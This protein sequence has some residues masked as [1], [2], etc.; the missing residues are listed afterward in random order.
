MS[1]SLM[2]N[3]PAPSARLL[4][5]IAVLAA[6][7]APLLATTDKAEARRNSS[8]SARPAEAKPAP[9]KGPL[10]LVVSLRR[11]R[12][13][14]YGPD[15]KITESPVSTGRSGHETPTGVFSVIGKEVMHYSNLYGDAPMPFMNRITWSGVALH[16]GALPGYPASHGC[17]RLPY[18]FARSLYGM[19]KVGTRVIVAHDDATPSSIVH[20]NLF[21]PLP[22]EGTSSLVTAATVAT[23]MATAV[24]SSGVISALIGITPA[25]AAEPRGLERPVRTREM[26]VAERAEELNNIIAR[27]KAAED[28]KA[29]REPKA[30]AATQDAIEARL[31]QRNLQVES[32]RLANEIKRL[33][34]AIENAKR[35]FEKL[36]RVSERV[37]GERAMMRAVEK[38]EALEKTLMESSAALEKTRA[39]LGEVEAKFKSAEESVERAESA[40]AT[41]FDELKTV[42]DEL[43]TGQAEKAAAEKAAANR[44]KPITVLISR[45]SGKLHV[46]Q[47]YDDVF[48]SPVTIAEP[49]RPFGTHV[50]TAV[51]YTEGE[52]NLR[53][54]VVTA[55][56]D[57]PRKSRE[58]R[59][60]NRRKEQERSEAPA[61]APSDPTQALARVTIPA[62]ARERIAELIKPGSTLMLS[63]HGISHE[64]GKY[65][66]YILLTR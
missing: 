33:E 25:A 18:G 5:L 49:E 1:R 2:R 39:Q 52:K 19:T 43:R 61:L 11:Q 15:G 17:I 22:S 55:A 4:H 41:A 60:R 9:P 44:A 42:L 58:Q 14:V 27:V 21:K 50:Y 8:R 24:D 37:Q 65:T 48:E 10:T 56:Q 63:D 46:R 30:R 66:D 62:Q 51:A 54:N 3:V 13:S 32:V 31:A 12:V 59:S 7:A 34:G 38:E 57:A 36:A 35:D 23:S 53:W 29:E 28:R 20:D 45:K 40:R 47:G 64:T 26:V 6:A 16:A